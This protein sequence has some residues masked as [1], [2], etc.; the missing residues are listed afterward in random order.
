M[1]ALQIIDLASGPGEPTCHLANSIPGAKIMCTD[2]SED[3]VAKATKRAA[4]KGLSNV[5]CA[6]V[7]ACDLKDVQSGSQVVP[8]LKLSHKCMC[9]LSMC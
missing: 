5:T 8:C 1:L 7:D 4:A 3:M 6:V 2:V 9:V